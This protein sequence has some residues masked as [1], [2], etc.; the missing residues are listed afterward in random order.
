MTPTHTHVTQRTITSPLEMLSRY[1]LS[2]RI[3]DAT[4]I[5]NG[6]DVKTIAVSIVDE[7]FVE[8]KTRVIAHI[9][10][11][12]KI[13]PG[14]KKALTRDFGGKV[15]KLEQ[16]YDRLVLCRSFVGFVTFSFNW[17]SLHFRDITEGTLFYVYCRDEVK[18]AQVF[19][20]RNCAWIGMTICIFEPV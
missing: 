9:L 10:Q 1:I 5:V 16:P 11:I 3:E 13:Q 2:G 4:A 12:K 19:L 7:D 14:K 20:M 18:A 15:M 17:C 6:D 8:E